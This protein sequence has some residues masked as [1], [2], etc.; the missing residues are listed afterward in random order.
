L[1]ALNPLLFVTA[2]PEESAIWA[3]IEPHPPPAASERIRVAPTG[4]GAEKLPLLLA[5]GKTYFVEDGLDTCYL[6]N[7]HGIVPIV[8]EQPWNQ[9]PH[10]F[11]KVRSWAGLAGRIEWDAAF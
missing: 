8:Y 5:Q 10:P 3:W 2:R 9:G 6:F 4:T 7:Q 1:A 11:C